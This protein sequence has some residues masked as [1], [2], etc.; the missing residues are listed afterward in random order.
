L[1][2]HRQQ[3]SNFMSSESEVRRRIGERGKV[4]FAE[5]MS[6]ALYWPHGGYYM[7][8][9]PVG[10]QGDY[11]TSPAVHPAFGA[12]LAV[13]LFQMWREM[14]SPS[15]FT[16][17]ELGAG[18]GLLCRDV[19][20]Y[21]KELPQ[22]FAA[23]LRYVCLDRRAPDPIE[24]GIPVTDRVMADG[25][26]FKGIQG[27]ILSNEYLDAFP[28][29]QVTMTADGLQEVF[30]S[31]EDEDLVEVLG[32]L[33]D[34]GLAGRLENLGITLAEGQTAEINLGLERWTQEVTGALERGYVLTIDYGR[35]APDLYDPDARPRGTLVTY[36]QHLQTDAP[37][38]RIGEQD[39]TAQ[40]DFTSTARAGEKAGLET[41]GLVTQREFLS[42]L[43]LGI[44]QQQLGSH[45]L[46]PSQFQ[47]NRAGMIDLARPGGLGEF[48]VLIQ[49]KGMGSKRV[50]GLERSDDCS[51]L[52][53]G[54]PAPLLTS[55]HLSLPDGRFPGGET[56]FEAFWPFPDAEFPPQ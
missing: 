42:N 12:L 25:L 35:T 22:G 49:G 36:H 48:K 30:V 5:F 15:S 41:L 7:G 54:L 31:V 44:L 40:V 14:D 47:A 16:V 10:A 23:A 3:L 6:V 33:S 11:Y 51:A 17:L 55:Q 39:I 28:V 43:N 45:S 2:L 19:M 4:T 29:H 32:E 46:S 20:A 8:R 34:T 52:V 24:K 27:C 13:Q 21:A 18:N 38:T 50:W 26:P 37:L 1:A 53:E 56:E 9:E